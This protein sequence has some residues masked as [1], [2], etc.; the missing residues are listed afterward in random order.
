[1]VIFDIGDLH[2]FRCAVGVCIGDLVYDVV[3]I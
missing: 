1:M 2:D 3:K